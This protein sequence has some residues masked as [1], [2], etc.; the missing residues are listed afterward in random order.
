V[1]QFTKIYRI[2]EHRNVRW[3]EV[4]SLMIESLMLKKKRECERKK[5]EWST[6]EEV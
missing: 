5:E 3:R 4:P 6:C 1:N 2:D